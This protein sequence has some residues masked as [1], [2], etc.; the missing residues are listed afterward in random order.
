MGGAPGPLH[1]ESQCR[2]RPMQHVISA[3][4]GGL[5]TT[6]LVTLLEVVETRVQTQHAVRHQT[7]STVSKLCYVFHNSLMTHV[8]KQNAELFTKPERDLKKMRT[9][10]EVMKKL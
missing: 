1:Q 7:P 6:F 4:I 10:R 5:I 9:L 3:L 8:C 2:I